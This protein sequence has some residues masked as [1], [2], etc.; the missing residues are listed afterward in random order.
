MAKREYIEAN[1]RWLEEKKKE[2]GVKGLEKGVMYKV[3]KQGEGSGASPSPR[4]IVT[5]HYTGR[6]INGR[7]FDSS[8][9]GAP[10]ACRLCDLIEGWI[11][12]LQ[13]MH[14]ATNGNCICQ[15]MWLMASFRNREYLA[16]RRWCLKWSCWAWAKCLPNMQSS[17]KKEDKNRGE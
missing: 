9:G 3:I 17:C 8:L 5:V 7:K 16:A 12:A 2:E 6:T 10:L 14:V 15:P 4:S 1:K 13:Q 11:I